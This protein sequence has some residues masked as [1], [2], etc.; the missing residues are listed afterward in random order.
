M[1]LHDGQINHAGTAKQLDVEAVA[2]GGATHHAAE[3]PDDSAGWLHDEPEDESD[4]N[5]KTQAGTVTKT[6]QNAN[7]DADPIAHPV[8]DRSGGRNPGRHADSS[9]SEL[10][11]EQRDDQLTRHAGVSTAS[12][13]AAA[14]GVAHESVTGRHSSDSPRESTEFS[15][16]GMPE[17]DQQRNDTPGTPGKPE[18]DPT[19]NASAASQGSASPIAQLSQAHAEDE[20]G[21]GPSDTVPDEQALRELAA[22]DGIDLDNLTAE[23]AEQLGISATA[24]AAASEEEVVSDDLT[25]IDG[26]GPAL[27][28]R[29]NSFGYTRWAQLAEL[30]DEAIEKLSVQLE[31]DDEVR[32][33]DWR[34]Q[35]MQLMESER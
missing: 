16:D 4:T 26:V 21:F 15:K 24:T 17:I 7:A 3:L 23:Q 8:A 5:L 28:E 29:L 25:R 31:L 20:H 33:Q 10:E 13:G 14:S 22:V 9:Q 27:Q 12:S 1:L 2:F 32:D 19:Q 6:D 30:D 34:A 11:T 18:T 35:A